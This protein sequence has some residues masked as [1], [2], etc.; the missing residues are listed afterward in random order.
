MFRAFSSAR[1]EIAALMLPV[2]KPTATVFTAENGRHLYAYKRAVYLE[3][4][5]RFT[6][7]PCTQVYPEKGETVYE[8]AGGT[9][10]VRTEKGRDL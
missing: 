8:T 2:I 3:Q 1:S 7:Y 4:E 10:R 6:E 5:G 9:V